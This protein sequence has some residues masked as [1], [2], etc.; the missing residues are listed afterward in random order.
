VGTWCCVLGAVWVGAGAVCIWSNPCLEGC[1]GAL[2]P[3]VYGGGTG[4]MGM[5]F[6]VLLTI[7]TYI[8]LSIYLSVHPSIHPSIHLPIYLSIH[9]YIHTSIHT[10]ILLPSIFSSIHPF[11][12]I[13]TCLLIYIRATPGPSLINTSQTS[14]SIWFVCPNT[15]QP[16]KQ[17]AKLSLSSTSKHPAPT[18]GTWA[19]C[20]A[21]SP[22]STTH[23][24]MH[25]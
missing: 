24:A 9:P 6:W 3:A 22:L 14:D 7:H 5:I 15:M 2:L 16:T 8:Y 23:N 25:C 13:P 4:E 11:N 10:F 17:K 21:Q 1:L 12:H 18:N 20:N 19:T